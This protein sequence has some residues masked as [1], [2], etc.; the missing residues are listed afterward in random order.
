[1][2]ADRS[3]RERVK[4]ILA[5]TE[6]RS[7]EKLAELV[8]RYGLSRKQRAAIYPL[9]VAHDRDAHPAMLVAG[10]AL[11]DVS[12]GSSLEEDIYPFLND[13]QQELLEENS[14]D[15]DAWWG[16]IAS[17]LQDDL[18]GAMDSGEVMLP[19]PDPKP[20]ALPLSGP[21]P[22]DGAASTHDGGNLFDLLKGN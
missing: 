10:S 20:S 22:G 17:Q 3:D 5:G 1:M 2:P 14:L 11:P 4:G 15:Q 8:K 9:I 21:A 6:M 16:E 7:Q 12:N 13:E 19:Q 18:T